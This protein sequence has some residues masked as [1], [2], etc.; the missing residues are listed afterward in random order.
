MTDLADG[1]ACSSGPIGA[2][3]HGRLRMT[4]GASRR[5]GFLQ[6]ERRLS[7]SGGSG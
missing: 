1:G 5:L 6:F 3:R 4:D 2:P 7:A